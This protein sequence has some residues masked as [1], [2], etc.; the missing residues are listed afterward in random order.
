[1]V[2]V[3]A[4]FTILPDQDDYIFGPEDID[5]TI[6]A[7]PVAQTVGLAPTS[8]S[9]PM[10][11]SV[12]ILNQRTTA[13]SAK[14]RS[15]VPETVKIWYENGR[16]GSFQGTLTLGKEYTLNTYE[17][18]VFFFTNEA[19]TKEFAR[20]RMNKNR[21]RYNATPFCCSAVLCSIRFHAL[22]LLHS[23]CVVVL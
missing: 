15:M 2:M 17:D 9:R 20:F 5:P 18:H 3:I 22:V 11:H 8:A 21:V 1:M 16:G 7:L 23:R 19:K 13:V 6:A 4:Q 10:H 14:F 12:K